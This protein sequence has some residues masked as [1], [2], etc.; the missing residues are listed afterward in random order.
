MTD[1]DLE[2]DK[3]ETVKFLHD[4]NINTAF[5]VLGNSY[6]ELLRAVL[7]YKPNYSCNIS[8]NGLNT[9]DAIDVGGILGGDISDSNPDNNPDS[10]GNSDIIIEPI[11]N[12]D[13]FNDEDSGVPPQGSENHVTKLGRVFR[14]LVAIPSEGSYVGFSNAP[15]YSFMGDTRKAFCDELITY[16]SSLQDTFYSHYS[17]I[18]F[19]EALSSEEE[20]NLKD[21][22]VSFMGN[23][24]NNNPNYNLELKEIPQTIGDYPAIVSN[25]LYVGHVNTLSLDYVPQ[26][27]YSLDEQDFLNWFKG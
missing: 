14:V 11:Y 7:N 2:K 10:S 8:T 22:F 13:I 16:L 3:P 12:G 24:I 27:V 21:L 17:D 26:D 23:V 6:V 25:Q 19:K 5:L 1:I 18:Y 20:K 9:V 4:L 15:P